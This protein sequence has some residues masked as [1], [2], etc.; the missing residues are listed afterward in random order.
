MGAEGELVAG[1]LA[2]GCR[3]VAACVDG[4]V[5]GYG[6]LATGPEWIGE[7]GL[8]LRPAPG[9]AYVWNCVTLEGWRRRGVFRSLLLAIVAA[10]RAEGLARLW[11]GSL[12]D[13]P[14]IAAVVDAGFAPVLVVENRCLAGWRLATA[15]A[16]PGASA[17]AVAAARRS[18]GALPAFGRQPARVH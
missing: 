14:A 2:R 9:E 17:E 11:I 12:G 7:V 18:L 13:A 15:H 16:A 3:C 1:R 6:W 5:A 4:T 8:E 10:A